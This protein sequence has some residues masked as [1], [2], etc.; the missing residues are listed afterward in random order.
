ME[1]AR[2]LMPHARSDDDGSVIA[3]V[4]ARQHRPSEPDRGDM[5]GRPALPT[6]PPGDGG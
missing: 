4:R 5:H 2:P 3:Q 1:R 6:A